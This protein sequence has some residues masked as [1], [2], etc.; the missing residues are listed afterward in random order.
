[1]PM[2]IFVKCYPWKPLDRGE[3]TSVNT[4]F[5]TMLLNR[6]LAITDFLSVKHSKGVPS[7]KY[8][9]AATCNR[10]RILP[11]RTL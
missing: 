10:F 6:S 3:T 11:L 9:N 2:D 7:L 4:D 1:M 8:H 5:C